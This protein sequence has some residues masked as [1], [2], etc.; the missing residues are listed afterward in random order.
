MKILQLYVIVSHWVGFD[1]PQLHWRLS[2]DPI[3]EDESE[4]MRDMAVRSQVKCKIFLGYTSN[5]ISAGTREVIR[6]L[7][8]HKLV[9][10]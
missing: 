7:V 8:E 3:Q 2:D 6:F 1:S 4:D 10:L 5:M 9:G